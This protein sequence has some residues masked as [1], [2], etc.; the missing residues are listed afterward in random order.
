MHIRTLNF[1]V[2]ILFVHPEFLVGKPKTKT[3]PLLFRSRLFDYLIL[4]RQPGDQPATLP[5][6]QTSVSAALSQSLL[7]LLCSGRSKFPQRWNSRAERVR[8]CQACR[9]TNTGKY[10]CSSLSMLLCQH[11]I[12]NRASKFRIRRRLVIKIVE[13]QK[14]CCYYS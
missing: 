3:L 11:I 5:S 6:L 10:C 1:S 12:G 14:L 9:A 7:T 2:C 4:W 13:C 8:M